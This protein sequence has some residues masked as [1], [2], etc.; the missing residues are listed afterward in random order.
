MKWCTVQWIWTTTNTQKKGE[1]TWSHFTVSGKACRT[2]V[3]CNKNLVT[4]FYS[5]EIDGDEVGA[6]DYCCKSDYPCGYSQGF[7]YPWYVKENRNWHVIEF[8]MK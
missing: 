7:E 3:A 1:N 4:G 2:G 8:E 5:C 6:W